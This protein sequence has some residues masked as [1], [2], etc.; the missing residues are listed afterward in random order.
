MK[1]NKDI[2]QVKIQSI[3]T[4]PD[5]CPSEG[6]TVN[7]EGFCNFDRYGY[8]VGWVG[9]DKKKSLFKKDISNDST[10][11]LDK[12]ISELQHIEKTQTIVGENDELIGVDFIYLPYINKSHS[13]FQPTIT[14]K[15]V[16]AC[17]NV[18]YNVTYEVGFAAG[19][20]YTRYMTFNYHTEGS[21]STSPY[22]C[23]STLAEEIDDIV[24]V[25]GSGVYKDSD[26]LSV[27]FFDHTGN[28]LAIGVGYISNLLDMLF[29]F[30]VIKL[31]HKIVNN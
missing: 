29:S 19:E 31:E 17:S 2:I 12:V 26:G 15:Y 10:E 5:W 28:K 16:D 21:Y 22:S 20:E 18:I 14:N 24:N 23:L 25:K 13:V 6:L 3:Q 7:Y 4:L 30:R 8:C 1:A 9:N 27:D 11:L